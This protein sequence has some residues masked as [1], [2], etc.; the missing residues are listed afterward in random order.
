MNM[1]CRYFPI[2]DPRIV[3]HDPLFRLQE[4][5][6]EK[7]LE[8]RDAGSAFRRD[9]NSFVARELHSGFDHLFIAD[10]HGRPATLGEPHRAPGNR[11]AL[12]A[13]ADRSPPC[14]RSRKIHCGIS[15]PRKP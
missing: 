14:E 8:R 12:S 7:L 11:P 9:E 4:P 15:L 10:S 3:D 1:L 2:P 5:V 6:R 13:H